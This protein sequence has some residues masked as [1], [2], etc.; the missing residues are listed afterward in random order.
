MKKPRKI[1]LNKIKTYS[2]KNRKTKVAFNDFAKVSGKA[3]S[4]KQFYDS[5]PKFLAANSLKAIVQAIIS[6][7]KNNKPVILGMG[8]HVIK[9]G[10]NP[11]IIDLMKKNLITC[12]ALNGAGAI[13]D[14]EIATLGRTSEDVGEGLETGLF[15]M[16][17]ETQTDMNTAIAGLA[18]SEAEPRG[19]GALLGKK[20]AQLKAPYRQ[21]S[22]L[23]NAFEL[24]VPVTVHVAIGTDTIHM[25][26]Q[27]DARSLGEATFNDFQYLAYEVAQLEG[28]VYIN[29]GSAVLLP[30]VFLKALTIAR[31]LGNKVKAFTTVNMDM[32]QH[33]RPHQNVLSRPGGR[34]FAL[35]GHHEIMFPLLYQ[36]VMESL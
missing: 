18:D 25:S 32:L 11:L 21:H 12:L 8:A 13:H 34:A 29:L 27:V 28:G 26:P 20:L 10:L 19:L 31:N 35:T 6:A 7:R 2:V 30:E 17:K 3:A 36:A 5:L 15:G 22:L 33:Y 9:V 14:F 4:F 23:Y 24:N 1:D 16:V